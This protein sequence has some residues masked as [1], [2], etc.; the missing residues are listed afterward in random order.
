MEDKIKIYKYLVIFLWVFSVAGAVYYYG[1]GDKCSG[2]KSFKCE[3]TASLGASKF[4]PTGENFPDPE[5][6]KNSNKE[7]LD[8]SHGAY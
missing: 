2:T 5:F 1:A 7:A 3:N 8:L 4:K 6:V